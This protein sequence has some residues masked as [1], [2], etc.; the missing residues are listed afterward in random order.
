[1]RVCEVGVDDINTSAQM[2][3]L[4]TTIPN[5]T[6]SYTCLTPRTSHTPP[7]C[8]PLIAT[9]LNEVAREA[10]APVTLGAGP[11]VHA[12]PSAQNLVTPLG[13]AAPRQSAT[14]LHI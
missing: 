6:P 10:R 11:R 1:M 14:A 9:H 13:V 4:T 12:I 8:H 2:S 7:H 3:D 5:Q